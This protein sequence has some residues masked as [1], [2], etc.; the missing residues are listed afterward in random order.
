M[1]LTK[2]CGLAALCVASFSM[3]AL[4]EAQAN[5]WTV[6]DMKNDRKTIF[7]FEKR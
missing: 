7:L 1:N 6:D 5:S 4:D 2:R 3:P